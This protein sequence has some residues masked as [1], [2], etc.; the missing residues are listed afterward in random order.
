MA[1]GTVIFTGGDGFVMTVP[2]D[3]GEKDYIWNYWLFGPSYSSPLVTADGTVYGMGSSRELH[4]LQNGAPLVR[5][6]WPTF[7]GN[8]QR[9]G[10]APAR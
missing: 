7:R 8:S 4:A 9:N 6:P 3:N 2:V 5:S 10:R 1:D